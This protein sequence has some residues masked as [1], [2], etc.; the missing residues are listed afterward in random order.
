M[1]KEPTAKQLAARAAFSAKYGKGRNGKPK[2]SHQK[3]ED[4]IKQGKVKVPR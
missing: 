2:T 4:L 1:A 3:M